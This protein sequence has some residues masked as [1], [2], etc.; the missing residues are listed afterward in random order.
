[1]TLVRRGFKN[2]TEKKLVNK[3]IK[4]NIYLKVLEKVFFVITAAAFHLKQI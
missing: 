2:A 1:M 4:K 3:N